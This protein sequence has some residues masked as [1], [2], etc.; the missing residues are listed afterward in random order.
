MAE[1]LRFQLNVAP[2]ISLASMVGAPGA[3]AIKARFQQKVRNSTS[4]LALVES[5]VHRS[6]RSDF[7]D[8][9]EMMENVNYLFYLGA[10]CAV[11]ALPDYSILTRPKVRKPLPVD[12][13]S[14]PGNAAYL[15]DM[16]RSSASLILRL[17]CKMFK[18]KANLK[19]IDEDRN[20]SA[21]C[22]VEDEKHVLED[23]PLYANIRQQYAPDDVAYSMIH[24]LDSL[25]LMKMAEFAEKIEVA[26]GLIK[27][28]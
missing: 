24:S 26:V 14:T 1:Y 8:L 5:Q 27:Q 2:H 4:L 12:T 3:L 21:C 19:S 25:Q 7:D 16:P 18:V 6:F 10:N 11:D 13:S 15:R 9:S 22:V 28:A 23:C 20:C 17:R